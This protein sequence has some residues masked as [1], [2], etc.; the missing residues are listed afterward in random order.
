MDELPFPDNSFDAVVTSL[1]IHATPPEVRRVAIGE[2]RRVLKP[3]GIFGLV[4]WSRPRF[5]LWGLLWLPMLLPRMKGDNWRNTY[6]D[7][8]RQRRMELEKD[9]YVNSLVRCQI[10]RK[11]ENDQN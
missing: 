5:G 2:I 4:D 7:I 11:Y 3:G 8:C 6:P 10:F 9:V 1:A